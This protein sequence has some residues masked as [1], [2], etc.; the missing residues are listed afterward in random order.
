MPVCVHACLRACAAL[1]SGDVAVVDFVGTRLFF[2]NL[3]NEFF[4]S[5]YFFFKSSSGRICG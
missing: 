1:K 5:F 3:L 2:K 4:V